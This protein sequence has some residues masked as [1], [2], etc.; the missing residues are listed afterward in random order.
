MNA[1]PS[2]CRLQSE[3]FPIRRF[4]DGQSWRVLH[5]YSCNTHTCFCSVSNGTDVSSSKKSWPIGHRRRVPAR[6]DFEQELRFIEREQFTVT[7]TK[8]NAKTS[9]NTWRAA[10]RAAD[11][12]SR[13]IVRV[14]SLA[15]GYSAT[16]PSRQSSVHRRAVNINHSPPFVVFSAIS[17]RAER[18]MH[19]E[20]LASRR[21]C[22]AVELCY[23]IEMRCTSDVF[24][25]S[26]GCT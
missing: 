19:S 21:T 24:I 3:S 5:S 22:T 10:S 11:A 9:T 4:R 18:M 26:P 25:A 1:R 13:V 23:A 2:A 17:P 16:K 8:K 20:L 6:E 15:R 12:W 14:E 7:P